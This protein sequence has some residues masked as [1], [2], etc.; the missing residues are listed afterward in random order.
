MKIVSNCLAVSLIAA[1]G[2]RAAALFS[3]WSESVFAAPLG[4]PDK[5]EV[6][7]GALIVDHQITSSS[8]V[9]APADFIACRMASRSCG[10]APS[11]LSALTTSASLVPAGI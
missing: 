3:A 9:S 5:A 7:D 2:S 4:T 1:F 10:V 6:G 8:A 11:E